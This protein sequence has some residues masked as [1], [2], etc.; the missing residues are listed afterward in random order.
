[1]AAWDGISL[2]S[3]R[4]DNGNVGDITGM[5][6]DPASA[7]QKIMDR[8]IVYVPVMHWWQMEKL[9]LNKP[10]NDGGMIPRVS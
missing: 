9:R 5:T 6:Y 2:D 10:S 1:M 7:Q 3:A 4:Q 8:F